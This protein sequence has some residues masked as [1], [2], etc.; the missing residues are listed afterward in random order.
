MDFNEE[1]KKIIE[2]ISGVYIISAPVGTGKTTILTERVAKA[3]ESGIKPE[4]I[5]CLTFTNR[6]AE[7]MSGRIRA[8]INNKKIY[9]EITIKTFHGWCAYFIKTESKRI[10]LPRDFVIF[11]EEEQREV[12]QKILVR[13]PEVSLNQE[14][15]NREISDLIEK[16]YDHRLNLLLRE[17]GCQVEE[18]P[19][20]K[21]LEILGLEY[22]QALADQCALDFNELVL[23]TLRTLYL[24]EKIRNKWAQK[25]RFIQLD[26]FQ[27]THLSEYLVVKELAKIQKNIAFIG[28]LDQTIYSWRGSQPLFIVKLI[29]SH[30]PG[31]Q[32]LSLSTNYRFNTNVLEAVKSFLASFIKP[33]TKVLMTLKENDSL[34][35]AVNVFSAR[36][37]REEIS[38]VIEKIKDLRKR[39]PEAKI[40]VI[41]RTNYLIAKTADIFTDKGVAH[42][43]VDK[44][45][46]FRR[47]EV[48]DVYAYLK[49]I[50]NRFDLEAAYRLVKRPPRNIGSATLKAIVEKGDT[51]CL[52]VSD[53]LN[54]KNYKYP[55]PFFNLI[56]RFD[57]GRLVVLDTE[58]TGTD[59]LSDDIIQIFARE[60]INGQEARR[61]H[62]YLKNNIPVGFSESIHGLSDKF[63]REKGEEPKKVLAELKEFIGPDAAIGHNVNFDLSMLAEN[64]KR[65]GVNF[66]FKEFYDTLDLAKRVVEA[67]NYRLSTLAGI[68]GLSSATH[69]AKD[70]V[71]ATVGLLAVLIERLKKGAGQRVALWQEYSAKFL[72][73]SATIDSW[74]KTAA[75]NRPA[76][77]LKK[78]WEESG[79]REYYASEPM[80]D[81][82]ASAKTS[83][84]N[85]QKSIE[86]LIKVF[87]EKDNPN[88]PAEISLQ[89]L[90]H[91]AA[92][93]KDINFL[94]LEKGKIPIVTAHQIKGLEFDYVF[95][96]GM[97]EYIFPIKKSDLEEEKRLFYVAMTRAKKK[98]FIS[99]SQFND[100]DY[101]ATKSRFIDY[102]DEKH[103]EFIS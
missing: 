73:L 16:V 31:V 13:H 40:T 26:E 87:A 36:N 76:E 18:A 84:D 63:L 57:R 99:Y 25:Y 103:I 77:F 49:I 100:N 62:H 20:D 2:S 67:P 7:E 81:G 51:A 15:I 59:V 4:E 3:I 42:I 53:F 94:G 101:P 95:I 91:Y 86:E 1:Q 93:V 30:F 52:K 69:D 50:F 8:R 32:E 48:K 98:I 27:D 65:R 39:E 43:T 11:E 38:W 17:I 6:A 60:I 88:K 70:D 80:L 10:G 46:F 23:L 35:K 28:D 37:F 44:Y 82:S 41:S 79:L 5:L 89:E 22:H 72:K 55:E 66:E 54:F 78:V 96:I 71:S 9:D 33:S 21:T 19:I 34:E 61:F 68:L 24:D 83:A 58:T 85:R 12:M 47:Q 97:N 74:Q 102:I 92:L 56:N 75:E 14:K 45:E 29:K 90:I 64:G